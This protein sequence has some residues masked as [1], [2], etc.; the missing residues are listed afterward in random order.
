[1]FRVITLQ[2]IHS[3]PQVWLIEADLQICEYDYIDSVISQ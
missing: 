3:F 2:L 1:M